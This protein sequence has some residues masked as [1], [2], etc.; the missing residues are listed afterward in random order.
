MIFEIAAGIIL[1]CVA[2][3]VLPFVLVVVATV[4]EWLFRNIL[5]L[6]AAIVFI[7]LMVGGTT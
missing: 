6:L 5:W 1:A 3:A 7:A 2:L 4:V